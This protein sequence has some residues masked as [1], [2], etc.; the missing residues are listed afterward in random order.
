[1]L[2]KYDGTSVTAETDIQC[3]LLVSSRCASEFLCQLREKTNERLKEEAYGSQHTHQ[4]KDPKEDAVNHHGNI[5]PIIL[6]L[7]EKRHT[8]REEMKG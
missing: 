7:S 6:H 1:M 8:I 3:L 2:N 5:L 4:H